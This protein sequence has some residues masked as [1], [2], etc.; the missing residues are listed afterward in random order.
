MRLIG[1]KFNIFFLLILLFLSSGCLSQQLT[2]HS[3]IVIFNDTLETIEYQL[4]LS[5][6][7][8]RPVRIISGEFDYVYEYEQEENIN[9]LPD[10]LSGVILLIDDCKLIFDKNKLKESFIADPDGRKTWNLHVTSDYIN[11][12]ECQ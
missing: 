8:T 3:A 2:R 12:I 4:T 9:S 11:S 7:I 6:K 1:A 5:G 10:E